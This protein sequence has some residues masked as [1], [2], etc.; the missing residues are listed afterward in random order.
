MTLNECLQGAQAQGVSDL[1]LSEDQPLRAR[2]QGCLQAWPPQAPLLLDTELMV[3]WLS[4]LFEAAADQGAPTAAKAALRQSWLSWLSQGERDASHSLGDVRV[5]INAFVHS[6]G[7]GASLRLIPHHLPSWQSLGIPNVAKSWLKEANGLILVTG[8][9][10]SGKSTTLAALVDHLNEHGQLHLITLEDPVEFVHRP[11]NSLIHQRQLHRDFTHF[12][13]GLKSA[14]RQD[15]DVILVG[16]LRDL[17]TIRLALQAAETGHLVL[18]SLHTRSA[19]QTIER[20]VDAF[21]ADEKPWIRNQLSLSLSAVICQHL[22]AHR[23]GQ[24]RV[25]AH[26]VMVATPAVRHLIR[27]G[28]TAQIH[29]A[30]QT[31][32]SVGMQ[33]FQQAMDGLHAQGLIDL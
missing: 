5:R 22:V 28:K 3:N 26:E 11:K 6:R 21:G 20:I 1:H 33:T 19:P 2:K 10:G 23:D 30:L 32:A 7:L 14:L 18:A 12:A 9:T 17:D 13:S 29:T 8:A 31:G 25:A 27:E 15:P 16:E 24:G 4:A